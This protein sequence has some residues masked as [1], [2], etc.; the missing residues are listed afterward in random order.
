MSQPP[1]GRVTQIS[2]SALP[3]E[4][5][6]V[7]LR[8]GKNDQAISKLRAIIAAH[9]NDIAAV[10]L[11]FD[12]HF[13]KRDWQSALALAQQLAKLRPQIANYQK[14]MISTLSNM[15]RYD[16][17]IAL[18]RNFSAR[19]GEDV[20]VLNIL[21]IAHFYTGSV[22]EAIRC[23]QRVM[24]MRDAEMCNRTA[25]LKLREPSKRSRT[26]YHRLHDLGRQSDL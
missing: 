9:P 4:S 8:A 25:P 18:A 1:T 15:K 6:C 23:G 26:Q 2:G 7:L 10:H 16:Q 20:E 24:E 5:I 13:Q 11:L 19:H 22:D 17:A 12:A 3:H 21:K 14:L